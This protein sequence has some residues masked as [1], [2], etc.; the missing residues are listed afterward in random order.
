[1]ETNPIF[2]ADVLIEKRQAGIVV[3]EGTRPFTVHLGSVVAAYPAMDDETL[4]IN[5]SVTV[6]EYAQAEVLI[7]VAYRD[8]MMRWQA[9]LD[10]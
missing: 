10:G 1:M 2:S 3:F 8:F 9:Y 5:P 6:V 4:E 7:R